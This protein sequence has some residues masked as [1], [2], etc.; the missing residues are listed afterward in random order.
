MWGLKYTLCF[1]LFIN[2][3]L[4]AE[5]LI[6]YALQSGQ[7]EVSSGSAE[8]S[9]EPSLQ[10]FLQ[11]YLRELSPIEDKTTRYL[12]NLNDLNGDGKKEVIVYVMGDSWCGSGGCT[13]L[14]L[15]PQG[16]YYK[17]VTKLTITNLP[18]CL[19]KTSSHG[20]HSL[21]VWVHRGGVLSPYE[22]E[23]RFDGKTYPEN[24][25]VPPARPFDGKVKRDVLIPSNYS[26]TIPLY[27]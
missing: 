10:A 27:P 21:T 25:T 12:Y 23:L 5:T 3:R 15:E 11:N 2:A 18:I 6:E 14:I 7:P 1:I 9:L 20:W 4:G 13:T 24:P 26:T 19:L 16:S 22:A 8:Q 17:V